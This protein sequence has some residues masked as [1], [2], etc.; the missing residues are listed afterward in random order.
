MASRNGCASLAATPKYD[1]LGVQQWYQ[2][3]GGPLGSHAAL[4]DLKLDAQGNVYV[5]GTALGDDYNWYLATI[6]YDPATGGTLWENRYRQGNGGFGGLSLA[7]DPQGSLYVLGYRQDLTTH[8]ND[9]VLLRYQGSGG[10]PDW[11]TRYGES[12]RTID[13]LTAHARLAMDR[14]GL[15]VGASAY[16]PGQPITLLHYVTLKYRQLVCLPAVLDY[17]LLY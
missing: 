7:P 17:L 15:Y 9:L 16:L 11:M 10:P 14:R 13:I 5:T 6:K 12:G 4:E 8:L 2:T 1:N 3:Y